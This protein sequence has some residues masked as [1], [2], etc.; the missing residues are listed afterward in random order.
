MPITLE[1]K[2]HTAVL[3]RRE[4]LLAG[5]SCG[6][7]GC[8]A[9]LRLPGPGAVA[10]QRL[11]GAAPTIALVS[12]SHVHF[13]ARWS[14]LGWTPAENLRRCVAE[15][16]DR[17]AREVLFAGDIANLCGRPE[18]YQRFAELIEPLR[19]RRARIHL[20]V[21]NHDDRGHLHA[22]TLGG[23]HTCEEK[24]GSSVEL[25]GV[26]WILLD[27]LAVVNEI[28]GSLGRPQL[29][30]LV[31]ELDEGD[32]RPTIVSV[33]HNP[34]P[35]LL[36]LLDYGD[37]LAILRPRRQVK[38]VVFGHTHL[39]RVWTDLHGLHYVNL[40]ALGFPF[41]LGPRVGY[42]LARMHAGGM[43]LQLKPVDADEPQTP[44]YLA[45]RE[46]HGEVS[47]GASQRWGPRRST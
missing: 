19:S 14:R 26:R 3:S 6:I 4:V 40:P 2:T 42:V 28:A 5:L 9:G 18:D 17:E 39:H 33:H 10:P 23:A 29:D 1:E 31:R 22:A 38:A 34:E 16:V 47:S 13:D 25:A 20:L 24:A 30:W 27:S 41:V 12:D 15:L 7:G 36:S 35:S 32:P 44:R 11:E 21:G 8:V 43:E 37:L 45:W 46:M